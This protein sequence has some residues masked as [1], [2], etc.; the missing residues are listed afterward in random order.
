MRLFPR[1]HGPS[2][3]DQVCS[4][5]NLTAAWRR[6]RSNIQV[7]RRGSSAGIDAVTLRDF[8]ADW[9]NQMNSLADDLRSGTYRPLPARRVAIPKASGGERVIAILTIR[10]RVAQRAMQQVLEPLF[11]PLLLDCSYG[12]RLRVGVPHALAQVQRYAERGLTWVVDADIASYFDQIDHRLL[13]GMVRQRID[14][15]PVLQVIHRWLEA[16][17]ADAPGLEP[18]T[19]TPPPAEQAE[20]HAAAWSESQTG[21][22]EGWERGSPML[23]PHAG[24]PPGGG[25]L[26]DWG[27]DPYAATR[28]G[29]GAAPGGWPPGRASTLP[30]LLLDERV[31][32]VAGLAQPVWSGVQRALPYMQRIGGQRV[33]LAAAAVATVAGAAAAGDAWLRRRQPQRGT[34]QGG[35]LSPLLANIYLHPFDLALT[36]Q[37][38]RLVRFM[39]DFVILCASQQEAEQALMLVHKQ[40]STLRLTLNEE[41]TRIVAYDD[42]L[43]FLGQALVP[44]QSG[45]R[46]IQGFSTFAEAERVLRETSSRVRQRWTKKR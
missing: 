35:A 37:G 40:L 1:Y 16:A 12:C 38:W 11:D 9:T 27:T 18:A 29:A 30:A 14:E 7:A 15:V 25:M 21:Q 39:D 42:G 44:R 45:R 17:V 13:L 23:P 2:V 19:W 41:K 28:W 26:P 20:Q 34:L 8:E 5:D 36:S 33:A 43:E 4:V 10:D 31:W 46:L 6:V 3:L 32:T 24:I 22:P